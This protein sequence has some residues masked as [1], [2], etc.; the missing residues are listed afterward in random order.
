[1]FKEWLQFE[2]QIHKNLF[3]SFSFDE[4]IKKIIISNEEKITNKLACQ[5]VCREWYKFL[6]KVLDTNETPVEIKNGFYYQFGNPN[7]AEGHTWL[8]INFDI[9]DPTAAQFKDFP[10]IS[11]NNY[12]ETD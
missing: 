3:F 10:N 11:E 9:F 5:V 7:L 6:I 1:M 4:N 8:E 12:V 2:N